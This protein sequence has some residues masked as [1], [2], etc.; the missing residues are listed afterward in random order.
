VSN[1]Y[2]LQG[3]IDPNEADNDGWDRYIDRGNRN[4]P[5][6]RSNIP[7]YYFGLNAG[8]TAINKL[9]TEFFSRGG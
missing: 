2:P 4:N 9:R 6:S 3:A 5:N 7:Y 8:K 1:G